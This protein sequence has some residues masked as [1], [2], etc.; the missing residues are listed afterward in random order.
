MEKTSFVMKVNE[1]EEYVCIGYAPGSCFANQIMMYQKRSVFDRY[2]VTLSYSKQCKD[3]FPFIDVLSLTG[4]LLGELDDTSISFSLWV[5]GVA[6]GRKYL[7]EQ[8]KMP[9]NDPSSSG[10]KLTKKIFIQVV[11][12]SAIT[13]GIS[14]GLFAASGGTIPVKREVVGRKTITLT[15]SCCE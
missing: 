3:S 7:V 1:R 14:F 6:Y 12:E 4:N 2:E 8:E 15:H 9:Q 10:K 11:R 13:S 5:V